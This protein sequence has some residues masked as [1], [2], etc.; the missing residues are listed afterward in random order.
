MNRSEHLAWC[1]QRAIE[2][3]DTGDHMGAWASMVSDMS[4]HEETDNHIAIELGMLQVFSGLLNSDTE[5]R[6]FINGFN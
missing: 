3:L 4:K 5:M 1:K 2:I 6:H